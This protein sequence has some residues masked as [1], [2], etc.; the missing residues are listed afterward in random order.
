MFGGGL[1]SSRDDSL[2]NFKKKFSK[3]IEKFYHGSI[4]INDDLYFKICDDWEKKSPEK[5]EEFGQFVLR[6]RY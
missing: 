2:L 3:E 1:S 6:Y 4:V 5:L